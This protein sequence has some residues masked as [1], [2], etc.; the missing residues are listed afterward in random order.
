M[1]ATP[2]TSNF[3]SEGRRLAF[4]THT[5]PLPA[6]S[7]ERIRI[8]NL[9]KTLAERGWD[10]SLFAL[11]P[12]SRIPADDDRRRL[13]DVC[14]QVVVAPFSTSRVRRGARLA[15]DV[16]RRR[17]FHTG[18]FV[19]PEAVSACHRWLAERDA[20]VIVASQ[21]YM[22]PYVPVELR[23]RVVLD[24]HNSEARRLETMAKAL[25]FSARGIAARL[26][27]D[28]VA[29]YER[30]VVERVARVVA[31]S[32][33]ERAY[34]EAFAPGRVDLVPN[35]V[36]CAAMPMLGDRPSEPR[37]LFLGSLDYSANVDA[38]V[39]L[40]HEIL[41]RLGREDV[42]VDVVGSNPRREVHRVARGSAIVLAGFVD[43]T[44]PYWERA[45]VFV[46]PLR[47]G[48]G[49]R[50]KIL[51]ALARGVPVVSTS[52][53]CEGLGLRHGEELLVAD[54]PGEFAGCVARLLEDDDLCRSL[55]AAGRATVE[56]R[57]DWRTIGADFEASLRAAM[58]GR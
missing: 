31:V 39:H 44:T 46:V 47:V 9:L 22:A 18:F 42:A 35:G 14:S 53:G 38:V 10:A 23:G 40:T 56:A 16:V 32:D 36:D 1:P 11:A 52:L 27:R 20:D 51:E 50:L 17:A 4:L 55:A 28:P 30:S 34:F 33:V 6:V 2:P 49:T 48:G 19:S 12:E 45:R 8:W 25:G 3:T 13:E 24:T 26:Q 43:D 15:S 5:P 29:R 37:L 58:A 54:D 57:F 21:L 41:P 7:G